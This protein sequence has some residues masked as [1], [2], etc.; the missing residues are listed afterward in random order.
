MYL[1]TLTLLILF[2]AAL[3][4]AT[5]GFGESILA[6]PLLTLVLGLQVAV[7]LMGLLAG[8]IT[9][10]LLVLMLCP[11]LTSAYSWMQ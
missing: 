4:K 8:A 1:I 3:T 9:L 2:I 5:L 6:I 7:P 11:M 10:M